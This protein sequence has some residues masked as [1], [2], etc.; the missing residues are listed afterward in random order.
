MVLTI[1]ITIVIY[2]IGLIAV[3]TKTGFVHLP[4][5]ALVLGNYRD[6]RHREEKFMAKIEGKIAPHMRRRGSSRIINIGSVLGFLPMPYGAGALYAATSMRWK[7]IRNR[8][9]RLDT[10]TA[11]QA[12]LARASI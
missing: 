12:R 9:T 6:R 8:S 7:A 5:F 4:A 3:V 10:P 11:P 2:A 1:I